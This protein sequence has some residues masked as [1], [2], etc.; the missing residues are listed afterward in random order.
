MS[1]DAGNSGPLAVIAAWLRAA[2]DLR[3]HLALPLSTNAQDYAQIWRDRVSP[4][5]WEMTPPSERKRQVAIVEILE[6]WR[7]LTFE[8]D[9]ALK[10]RRPPALAPCF[11]IPPPPPHSPT[12][13]GGA[14]AHVVLSG[15][16]TLVEPLSANGLLTA[17]QA[18]DIFSNLADVQRAARALT[19]G[20]ERRVQA[21]Q[22]M[23]RDIGDVL[24][25]RLRGLQTCAAYA[26]NLSRASQCLSA[27]A[28]AN[29]ALVPWLQAHGGWSLMTLDGFLVKPMQRVLK[30]ELQVG[31]PAAP[32]V[33]GP[34]TLTVSRPTRP[35][36]LAEN[37]GGGD[38]RQAPRLLAAQ[39]GAG[40]DG[41][42]GHVH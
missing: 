5:V 40:G 15:P 24:L 13:A 21:D 27:A 6:T 20:L 38:R 31:G 41:G 9:N 42:P 8:L 4:L 36:Y 10:V 3:A 26:A 1:D 25:D 14:G 39:G 29:P 33:T 32:H 17:E 19:E 12:R 18:L 30:L 22:Y 7:L 16:Q 35:A 23:V 2:G 28:A 34:A 37:G 11:C